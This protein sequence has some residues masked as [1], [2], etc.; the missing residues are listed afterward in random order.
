MIGMVIL[1]FLVGY[2]L[3]ILIAFLLARL[4]FPDIQKVAEKQNYERALLMH[5]A[6]RRHK[7]PARR[8]VVTAS[9]PAFRLDVSDTKLVS[10]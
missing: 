4:L 7:E 6:R 1:S 10:S 9:R 5:R 3:F 2:P 8:T